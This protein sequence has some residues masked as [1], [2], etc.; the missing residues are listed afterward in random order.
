MQLHTI[1]LMR[2]LLLGQSELQKK[3]VKATLLTF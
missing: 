1:V 2:Q 3:M